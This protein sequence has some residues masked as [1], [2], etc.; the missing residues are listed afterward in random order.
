MEANSLEFYEE[1]AEIYDEA[2]FTSSAGK[3]TDVM[4]KE[5]VLKSCDFTDTP[6]I[7]DVG[8]GTGRFAIEFAKNGAIV[9]GLDPSKSMIRIAKS[10]S[11]QRK[12]LRNMNLVVADAHKLP[13][14][15]D[16]FD[17][18]TSINVL[19]HIPDYTKVLAEIARI[20]KQKGYFLANFPSIQSF[21]LPIALF[22]NFRKRALF[23]NVYSRWFTLKEMRKSISEAGLS[24]QKI[25]GFPVSASPPLPKEFWF[26][27]IRII[28]KGQIF[29]SSLPKYISGCAFIKS[30]KTHE[31]E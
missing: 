31:A 24:V 1:E 26:F 11:V 19:N 3:L 2:R 21:Y 17:C 7:L 22:I 18:S 9:V 29:S 14:K 12:V 23:K 28:K 13:F 4:Q 10:K 15:N 8:T 5:I 6:L 25:E 27:V 30:Q 20:L 16:S